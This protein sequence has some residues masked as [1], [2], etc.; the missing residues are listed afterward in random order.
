MAGMWQ[1][2]RGFG[3]D[4]RKFAESNPK[5]DDILITG[6]IGTIFWSGMRIK[7]R[8]DAAAAADAADAAARSNNNN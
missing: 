6:I 2:I 5:M 7:R 8:N 4:V 1:A 3:S